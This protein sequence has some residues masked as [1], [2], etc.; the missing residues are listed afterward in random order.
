MKANSLIASCLAIL[1]AAVVYAQTNPQPTPRPAPTLSAPQPPAASARSAAATDLGATPLRSL[2]DKHC[3]G[4][5][6]ARLK[7]GGIA[8]DGRDVSDIATNPAAWERSVRKIRAG[9]MP[10][11]GSPRVDPAVREL[12]AAGLEAELDRHAVVQLP[13]PG[14]HRLNRSEYQNAIRDLLGLEVDAAKFLP[15]DDS[16]AGFDNMAGTLVMSPP[17]LEAYLSAA[18]RISRLAVGTALAPTQTVYRVPED[19]TQDYHVEGLP[20]GTRGGLLVR[21]EFPATASTR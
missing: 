13:P 5:H 15:T 11:A 17:L 8:L 12:L 1:A 2:V 6:S 14:L 7:S 10:P 9:M 21:H 3:V 18:G 19:A 4:C 20:F 16:T